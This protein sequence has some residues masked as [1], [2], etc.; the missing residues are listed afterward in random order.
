VPFTVPLAPTAVAEVGDAGNQA[1]AADDNG[2]DEH[3][4]PSVYVR[5]ELY[6]P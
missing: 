4:L 3:L 5:L 2:L 1:D 6:C